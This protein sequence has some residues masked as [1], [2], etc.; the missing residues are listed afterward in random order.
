MIERHYGT[1]L[2][3]AA[4]G[5]AERQAAFEVAQERATRDASEDV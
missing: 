2:T 3:G 4:A 5:I 1:L